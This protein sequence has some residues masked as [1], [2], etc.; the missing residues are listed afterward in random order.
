MKSSVRR[1]KGADEADL[2]RETEEEE[3]EEEEE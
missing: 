1:R 3:E 2:G